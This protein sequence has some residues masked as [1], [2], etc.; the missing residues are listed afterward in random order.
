MLRQ[1][2]L[3][4]LEFLRQAL[5]FRDNTTAHP[6]VERPEVGEDDVD[7]PWL[8]WHCVRLAAAMDSDGIAD[9]TVVTGWLDDAETDPLPEMR[10]AVES[11][12]SSQDGVSSRDSK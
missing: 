11:R 10:F 2:V 12:Q 7:V 9:E 4:G 5:V 1:P 3:S 8:R 6:F